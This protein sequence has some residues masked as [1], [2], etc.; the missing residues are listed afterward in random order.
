VEP[1]PRLFPAQAER[2]VVADNE[3]VRAFVSEVRAARAEE[4]HKAEHQLVVALQQIIE[5]YEMDDFEVLEML[6]RLVG[7]GIS[8]VSGGCVAE[9]A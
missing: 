4:L 3:K 1:L 7:V 9:D 6:H 5:S 8:R 2:C